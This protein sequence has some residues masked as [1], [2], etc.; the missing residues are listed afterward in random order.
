MRAPTI[1]SNPTNGT[2]ADEEDIRRIDAHA[3]LLRVLSAP[4]RRHVCDR[5][6]DDL[7]KRLLYAS[8]DTSRVIETFSP[9]LA[10]LS[11][12]SI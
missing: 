6:L 10:I 11:I 12:S 2:A 4:L 8:P 3:V 1:L 5:T 7:Q 9:F